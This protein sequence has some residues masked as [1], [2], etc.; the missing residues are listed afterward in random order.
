ML[1]NLSA[2]KPAI[3]IRVKIP[4]ALVIDWTESFEPILACKAAERR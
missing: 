3:R 1:G 4:I 2:G